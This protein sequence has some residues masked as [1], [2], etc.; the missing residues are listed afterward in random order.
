MRRDFYRLQNQLKMGT[1][2]GCLW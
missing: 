2:E 1:F